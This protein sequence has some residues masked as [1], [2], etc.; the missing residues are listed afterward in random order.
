[1]ALDGA[2]LLAVKQELQP[3]V[4]GRIE[5]V[6]QPKQADRKPQ[7]ASHVLYA[8]EKAPWQRQAH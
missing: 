3:L 7:G 2:F 5:K 4:G 8:A 6:Y 1:M